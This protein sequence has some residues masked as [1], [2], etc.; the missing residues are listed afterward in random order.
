[1]KANATELVSVA[2]QVWWVQC[3]L[4]VR[5]E[6]RDREG[7]SGQNNKCTIIRES[8][9]DGLTRQMKHA[10]RMLMRRMRHVPTW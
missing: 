5:G 6:G 9:G 4:G 8:T 10:P 7:D 2:L 3:M 1:M